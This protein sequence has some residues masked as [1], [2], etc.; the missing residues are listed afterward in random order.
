MITIRLSLTASNGIDLSL[1][2]EKT[3]RKI[4]LVTI[5]T[6]FK[7]LMPTHCFKGAHFVLALRPE[8]N[9]S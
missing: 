7:S 5:L 2:T 8:R 1:L 3:K 4:K 9:F 6:L